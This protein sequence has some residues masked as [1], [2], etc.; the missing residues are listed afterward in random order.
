VSVLLEVGDLH[1]SLGG[2]AILRGVNFQLLA[3]ETVGLVGES[4]SGKSTLARAIL[5][6]LH[7]AR[8]CVS[9]LGLDL[10]A[11]SAAML[12]AR[13]RDLQIVFQ[14]PLASLDPRM[15]VGQ[16]IAEPV[17]IFE[18]A[19]N[20]GAQRRLIDAML[21]RV[22][23][24]TGI[25][26]RYPHEL[27]GGQCQRVAIARAMILNP[28]VLV[29]DEVV[30]SLDVSIQ[31]Q[32]VNLLLDLQQETGMAILF[33]SHN[34][35]VVR[36]LSHRVLVMYLGKLVETAPCE[37]LFAAPMHPYTR[38]LLAA[39]PQGAGAGGEALPGHGRARRIEPAPGLEGAPGLEPAAGLLAVGCA[40]R[41]RCPY[42]LPV[43]ETADPPLIEV[44][45]GHR[46]ACHRSQ[47][48]LI[49]LSF[50]P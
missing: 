47:E 2:H 36:Q 29:C 26:G 6:L 16:A 43:C 31:G 46:V 10:L 32:I 18:A 38:A 28:K 34:L 7:P 12:R 49:P 40:F 45:A 19:L 24:S 21:E 30:S 35:A 3:G 23:L 25:A 42:V 1:V 15:T 44:A 4:G 17:E 13:R 41:D 48:T 14:D 5:R 39:V 11:C 33:I 20:G 27:S 50:P 37:A 9:F 22:G 8:G